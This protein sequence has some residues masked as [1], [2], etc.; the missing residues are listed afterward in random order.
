M[1][2][3]AGFTNQTNSASSTVPMFNLVG[4]TGRRLKLFDFISGSD[5]SPA[6]AATKFGFLRT[7]AAGTSSA[8][9]TPT[10]LDSADGA[11]IAVMD[12]A[13]SGNP[14]ITANSNLLNVAHNQRATFRW[15]AAPGSELVV[16]ATS[17]AG[18]ALLAIV[19]S[20]NANYAWTILWTE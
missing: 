11:A 8:S 20:A 19:A 12:T 10:K 1:A 5:A 3:Y 14:T 18:L 2:A 7:S 4:G 6:D 9:V 13:W 15:V 16:P 17:G